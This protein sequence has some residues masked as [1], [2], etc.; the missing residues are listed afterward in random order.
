MR[1]PSTAASSARAASWR[2]RRWPTWPRSAGDSAAAQALLERSLR[3]H[4]T[5]LAAGYELAQLLLAEEGADPDAVAERLAA[6]DRSELTW[7]VFLGTAFY[8]AGHAVHGERYFR[9][10][11]E[12]TAQHPAARVGLAE[13]LLSQHRYAEVGEEA[14]DLPANTPA[15]AASQRL[16]ALA[17]ALDGDPAAVEAAAAALGAG[18]GDPA[19]PA[20]L[21]AVGAAIAGSAPRP[22][23]PACAGGVLQMLDGLARLEEF[24]AFERVAPLVEAALHD[25][26]EATLALG[27]GFYL[28]RGFYRLA[29]ESAMAALEG[30]APDARALAL[31]G[32]SAVAEG[33]FE[34]AIP[35]LQGSL[36]LDPDQPSVA[37][38]LDDLQQR[39]AA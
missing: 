38:L 15:F 30:V 2:S 18:G 32:K 8:E 7:W 28:S 10:A 17:A 31:L 11:L 3:E 25:P 16:R 33:L 1:P 36:E 12:V 4:P 22:L 9:R 24:D 29:A 27:E 5:F 14:G 39:S 6:Y 37:R 26:R 20:T 35:V 21:R 23:D 19:D 13:A 34:D